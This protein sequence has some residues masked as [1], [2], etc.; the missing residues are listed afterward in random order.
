MTRGRYCHYYLHHHHYGVDSDWNGLNWIGLFPVPSLWLRRI[1][2]FSS[3]SSF[4][5]FSFPLFCSVLHL[6]SVGQMWQL[7]VSNNSKMYDWLVYVHWVNVW[8]S[9][10]YAPRNDVLQQQ[11]TILRAPT[12]N[13]YKNNPAVLEQKYFLGG[14]E[15]VSVDTND[16][17][18]N[19]IQKWE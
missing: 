7:M 16:E 12:V 2:R 11:M 13:S 17:S 3:G 19:Y 8:L 18:R 15:W 5:P 9:F 1:V 14:G 10:F 6:F 4:P